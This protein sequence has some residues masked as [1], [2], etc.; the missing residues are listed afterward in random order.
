M[1]DHVFSDAIGAVR[2]S[3]E[4]ALL[5]RRAVEERFTSDALSG[6]LRWETSYSLP[7][8]A[9]PPQVQVDI[10]LLWTTWSQAA[11]RT[12]YLNGELHSIPE[13]EFEVTFRK[14]DLSDSPNPRIVLGNL[15]EPPRL[16]RNQLEPVAGP[17][18]ETIYSDDLT[19][20]H[21][22]LEMQYSAPLELHTAVLAD[23]NQLD[24]LFGVVGGWISSA[25][26]ALT[27]R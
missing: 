16:G 19:E 20:S 25:L 17:T 4:L 15:P 2:S 1:L 18:V 24:E 23:G 21:Y 27:R 9:L 7:G 5:E 10:T 14:Q 3:L 26:V 6:D 22:A 12:W 13:L 11:Y 8:E